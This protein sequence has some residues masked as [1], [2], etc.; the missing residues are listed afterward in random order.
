MRARVALAL[1]PVCLLTGACG[2]SNRYA[3]YQDRKGAI[4]GIEALVA[5]IPQYPGAHRT[6]SQ[7]FGSSYKLSATSYIEAEPYSSALYYDL[8]TSVTGAT[9]QRYFRRVMIARGWNC[10]F[11]HRSRGVPYG[12][13]CDR[14]GASVGAYFADRGHYE[15]DVSTAQPRPPI[16]TV[17]GD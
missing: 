17:G 8:S 1:I 11:Q 9:L 2:G 16:P 12:F 15:F 5:T 4:A 7:W 6:G 10:S 13:A 14:R 3:R